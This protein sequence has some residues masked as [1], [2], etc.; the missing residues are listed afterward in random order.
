[1][2]RANDTD[3]YTTDAYVCRMGE[4]QDE[5]KYNPDNRCSMVDSCGEES[6]RSGRIPPRNRKSS[7]FWLMILLEVS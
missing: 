5:T 3:D 2:E 7:I 6:Y 4:V 1:M